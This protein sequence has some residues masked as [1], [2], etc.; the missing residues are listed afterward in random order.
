M[1]SQTLMV[2]SLEP[3]TISQAGV[4]LEA[5]YQRSTVA[6]VVSHRRLLNLIFKRVVVVI[7]STEMGRNNYESLT[8][9]FN[10]QLYICLLITY[11]RLLKKLMKPLHMYISGII[12]FNV[13]GDSPFLPSCRRFPQTLNHASGKL[14]VVS[15]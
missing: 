1:I 5:D 3:G 12:I 9:Y 10:S 11:G 4:S 13:V 14:L 2:L 6:Y 7:S 15:H 8:S